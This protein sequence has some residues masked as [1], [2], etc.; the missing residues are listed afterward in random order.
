[1]KAFRLKSY[2]RNIMFIPFV[3]SELVKTTQR[4]YTKATQE[5]YNTNAMKEKPKKENSKSHMQKR[6]NLST[7]IR[8]HVEE[9]FRQKLKW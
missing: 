5:N 9:N 1:M 4:D 6:N 7:V 3:K 2:F 8:S